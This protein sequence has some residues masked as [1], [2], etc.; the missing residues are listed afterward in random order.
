MQ[1]IIKYGGIGIVSVAFIGLVI[2][3]MMILSKPANAIEVWGQEKSEPFDECHDFKV[4]VMIC[5]NEGAEGLPM[6]DMVENTKEHYQEVICTQC[7][8]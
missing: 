5:M 4:D 1:E 7:V 2:Y 8:D 6:H 3:I